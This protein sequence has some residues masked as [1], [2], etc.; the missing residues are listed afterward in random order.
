MLKRVREKQALK[1]A[2]S[3]QDKNYRNMPDNQREDIAK[4]RT[5]L[6][7]IPLIQGPD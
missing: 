7:K 5:A 4:I 3:R 2:E 1:A 6:S